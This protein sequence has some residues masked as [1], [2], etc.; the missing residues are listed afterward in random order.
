[1]VLYRSLKLHQH[2]NKQF[3][4]SPLSETLWELFHVSNDVHFSFNVFKDD[5]LLS[6]DLLNIVALE[7]LNLISMN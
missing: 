3:Y 5:S 2:G 1:M 4:V 7:S 6:Q